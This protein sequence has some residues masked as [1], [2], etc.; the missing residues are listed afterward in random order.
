M[1]QYKKEVV[2]FIKLKLETI[3]ND[4]Q[5]ARDV[6]RN[7]PLNK[8]VEAVRAKVKSVK[9][10][11]RVKRSEKPIKRLFFDIET[12][13]IV[14]RAWRTGKQWVSAE[15]IMQDKKVICIC[16]K[17][18]F[19]DEVHTLVWDE[20]QND[21][22]IIKDFIKV[23]GEADEII[24]HNGDRFDIKEIRTR[25]IKEGVLMFPKYRTLD[26][27]KKARKY[28]NFHSNKLDYIGKVLNVGRKLDHEGFQL[29]ID[30]VENKKKKSLKKM[31]DY[32]I[33]DVI[34][35]EDVFAVLN[36]YIDHNTN[37]AVQKG[38]PKWKCPNCASG[39]VSLCHTDTTAM[40]YIKRHMKC[41][42]CKKQY[43]ISNKTYIEYLKKDI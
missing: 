16:Y 1:S 20:N 38:E 25:A 33:Q 13:Y 39:S 28:F 34:L 24:A 41:K 5:I 22:K 21:K 6:L 18:Q 7:F 32:C 2:E 26:T 37:F 31:V 4:T 11:L 23:L 42:K 17:W 29:W 10:D 3:Q 12:S 14:F 36:P 15:N 19:E 9:Q 30:V 35:L 27:L 8:S 40:G 43:N